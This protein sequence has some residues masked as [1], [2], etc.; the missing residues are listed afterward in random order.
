MEPFSAKQHLESGFF[1]KYREHFTA[2]GLQD[3]ERKGK[4]LRSFAL[5]ILAIFVAGFP[6]A[7]GRHNHPQGSLLYGGLVV[8]G[9]GR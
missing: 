1:A 9:A 5:H 2:Q 4:R 8:P 7:G 6:R 3:D